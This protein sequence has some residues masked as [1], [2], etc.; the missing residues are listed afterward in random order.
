M[1]KRERARRQGGQVTFTFS[2]AWGGYVDIQAESLDAAILILRRD[3]PEPGM[4]IFTGVRF[5]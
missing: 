5:E 2:R 1:N 4:W 3:H